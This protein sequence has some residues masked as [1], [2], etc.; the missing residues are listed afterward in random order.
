MRPKVS[1]IV[2]NY[3]HAPFLKDR[4]DSIFR[5]EFEDYEVILLDDC[6]TDGSRE[7]IES[8][9]DHEK[10][11]HVVLNERNSGSTFQQWKKG[12]QLAKGEYIWIA[13]SDDVA[14]SKLLRSLVERLDEDATVGIAY[15]QSLVINN[16]GDI[17]R[18]NI[19]HTY[20][21]GSV[22]WEKEFRMDGRRALVEFL[23]LKNIIPNASAVIFK[24]ALIR[25]LDEVAKFRFAGDWLLWV[26]ILKRGNLCYIPARLNY[27]RYHDQVSRNMNSI[28]KVSRYLQERY[29][30]LQA[31][32]RT[33]GISRRDLALGYEK[34]FKEWKK[35]VGPESI[36]SLPG[37]SVAGKLSMT[38]RS[39]LV[40]LLRTLG[41][42]IVSSHR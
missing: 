11:S 14:D 34:V 4:L 18:D 9:R 41:R 13:E 38:D 35:R 27:F 24:K 17:T 36:Q 1:V 31:I 6:S 19:Q 25:R 26:E 39:F 30:I 5:Q 21:F 40:Y 28:D 10:V 37:F 23:Q 16:K 3:N 42:R 15:C 12:I 22:N 29:K 2:P 32:E 20:G 7:I 33:D 8:Y